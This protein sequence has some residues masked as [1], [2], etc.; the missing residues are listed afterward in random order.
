MRR[1]LSLGTLLAVLAGLALAAPSTP[2]ASAATTNVSVADNLYMPASVTINVG[3]TAR[4]TW[5]GV[6]SH[7]VTAT[8]MSFDSGPPQSSGTFDH[9]FNTG[10]TFTYFCQVHGTA[11]SG[12]VVVQQAAAPTATAPPASTA[13]SAS[14]STNA[15]SAGASA[16]PGAVASPTARATVSSAG[17]TTSAA[18]PTTAAAP[19]GAA[20]AGTQLPRSGT[21]SSDAGSSSHELLLVILAGAGVGAI[22]TALAV[23]RKA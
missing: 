2:H 15:P 4:W 8:D 14:A 11:M 12:T 7:T 22:L 10:G 13:T 20:G 3:D 9:T 5:S 1:L 17:A 23:R 16:T 21:G 18:A 6:N 19:G